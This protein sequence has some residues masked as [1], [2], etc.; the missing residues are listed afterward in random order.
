MLVVFP[1]SSFLLFI[2][3]FFHLF[4][5]VHGPPPQCVTL[6]TMLTPITASTITEIH[7]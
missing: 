6:K 3:S 2:F 4:I 5:A 1:F 7:T